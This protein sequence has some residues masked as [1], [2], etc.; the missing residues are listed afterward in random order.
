[1]GS[2]PMASSEGDEWYACKQHRFY[3]RHQ[4]HSLKFTL[5]ADH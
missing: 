4:D 2:V 3:R 1:M 5:R